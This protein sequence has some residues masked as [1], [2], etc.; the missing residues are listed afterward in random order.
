M[1]GEMICVQWSSESTQSSIATGESLCSAE[2]P[3]Q[4]YMLRQWFNLL[5]QKW[6]NVRWKGYDSSRTVRGQST[7]AQRSRVATG[8]VLLCPHSACKHQIQL[9]EPERPPISLDLLEGGGISRVRG[10]ERMCC[11]HTG[12][13]GRNTASIGDSTDVGSVAL[14]ATVVIAG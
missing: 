7:Q 13:E 6:Q 4:Q 9:Q 2:S 3:A 5:S 8:C 14:K 11:V 1:D 10:R 12:V